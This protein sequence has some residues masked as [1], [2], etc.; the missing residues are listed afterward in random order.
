[1]YIKKI[2]NFVYNV[3]NYEKISNYFD[4]VNII[5]NGK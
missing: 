3:K 1:I 4:R 2:Y 5:I